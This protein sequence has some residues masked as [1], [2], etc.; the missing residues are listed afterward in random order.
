VSNSLSRSL[1]ASSSKKA[2]EQQVK[3]DVEDKKD[4][5]RE[6]IQNNSKAIDEIGQ[7]L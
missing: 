7:Q 3:A 4:R 2:Q 5:I 6:G 1:S